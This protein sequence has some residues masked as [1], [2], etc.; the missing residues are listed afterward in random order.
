VYA[1]YL[2]GSRAHACA[3]LAP[4]ERMISGPRYMTRPIPKPAEQFG[5]FERGT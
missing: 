5:L 2:V 1:R 4:P 3:A